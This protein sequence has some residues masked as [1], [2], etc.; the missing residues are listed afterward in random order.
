VHQTLG[1]LDRQVL[2]IGS[3]DSPRRIFR[4]PPLQPADYVERLAGS[5]SVSRNDAV[6]LGQRDG[7]PL[8]LREVV[9]LSVAEPHVDA[10]ELGSSEDQLDEQSA[11]GAQWAS[12]SRATADFRPRASASAYDKIADARAR[13]AERYAREREGSR[14]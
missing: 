14:D 2:P 13:M 6:A 8:V 11:G 5:I 9:E 10:L 1:G 12:A 7:S 3:D 4:E